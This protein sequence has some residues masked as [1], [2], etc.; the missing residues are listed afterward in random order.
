MFLILQSVGVDTR[1]SVY[2]KIKLKDE[3]PCLKGSQEILSIPFDETTENNFDYTERRHRP[4]I[5]P[6]KGSVAVDFKALSEAEQKF[7]LIGT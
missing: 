6:S 5:L 4:S 1:S 3:Q 2:F 7:P